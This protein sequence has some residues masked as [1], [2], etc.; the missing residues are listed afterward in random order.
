MPV[1]LCR[2]LGTEVV[3]AVNVNGDI[4]GKHFKK[5]PE[6]PSANAPLPGSSIIDRLSAELKNRANSIKLKMLETRAG[7][8]GVFD[9]IA[10][11]LNIMQDKITRSRMVG[12]P[13]N[14]LLQP[15]LAHI[16]LL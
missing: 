16:G 11:S 4:V 2:A 1:S 12:D 14:V 9:V 5:A 15:R 6:E 7:T 10:G 13:P 8:P 3:I